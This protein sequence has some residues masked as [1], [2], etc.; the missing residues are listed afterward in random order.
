M[1]KMAISSEALEQIRAHGE[2]SYP[3]EGAGLLLGKTGEGGRVVLGVHSLENR[4][5]GEARRKR[6]LIEAAQILRSGEQAESKGLEVVGVF[7]S[8]P[9]HPA[10]PS[11]TDREWALPWYSYV[12][13]S[14]EGGMAQVTT[15]G[16]L[17]EDRSGFEEE[18][19]ESGDGVVSGLN[20][21][22]RWR[23]GREQGAG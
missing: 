17:R 3:D 5:E 21:V 9:D 20:P 11:D 8:H 7:H 4:R 23:Q 18:R 16:R 14:V 6:Y 22:V 2:L 19:I 12:I 13:T 10:Q 1:N 15:S